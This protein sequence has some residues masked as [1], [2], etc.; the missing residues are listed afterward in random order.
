[1][2]TGIHQVFQFLAGLE[3]R[4]FLG[5]DFHAVTG[6]WISADTGLA[7]PSAE[8]AKAANFDL[9][10]HSKGAHDAVE[11]GLDDDFTIL[12]RQLR[13]AGD[14]IDQI[15]FCHT[16]L[17]PLVELEGIYFGRGLSQADGLQ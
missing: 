15:S 16:C 11:D 3:E 6:L 17:A 7:L 4:N 8:A 2:V 14:F 9:V 1:M 10:A 13:Q 5:G 12:A